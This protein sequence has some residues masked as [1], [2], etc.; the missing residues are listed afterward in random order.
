MEE[1]NNSKSVILFLNRQVFA[2]GITISMIG[3]LTGVVGIWVQGNGTCTTYCGTSFVDY[4]PAYL[5][6]AIFI[7]GI[8]IALTSLLARHGAMDRTS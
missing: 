6:I 5:G 3:V 1:A 4:T 7:V 8:V 2:L